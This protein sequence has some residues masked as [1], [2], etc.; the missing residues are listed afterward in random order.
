MFW[1]HPKLSVRLWIRNIARR[2][3]SARVITSP[4]VDSYQFM[5]TTK[6]IIERILFFI[7]FLVC[8][9]ISVY[10]VLQ[11]RDRLRLLGKLISRF[12]F[13]GAHIIIWTQVAHLHTL[14]NDWWKAA[15]IKG[16]DGYVGC[17]IVALR[18]IRLADFLN[19]MYVDQWRRW[20][21]V[22]K[23]Q[24]SHASLQYIKNHSFYLERKKLDQ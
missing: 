5:K 21:N 13:F 18:C 9:C 19:N 4:I 8:G 24:P 7:S 15:E 16:T 14:V 12:H 23:S 1:M 10:N 6:Y 22:R 20:S 11:C 3:S 17:K 2:D